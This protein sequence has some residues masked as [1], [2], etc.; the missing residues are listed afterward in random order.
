MCYK[1]TVTVIK[2]VGG[3]RSRKLDRKRCFEEVLAYDIIDAFKCQDVNLDSLTLTPET[4]SEPKNVARDA[5]TPHE[6]TK[7]CSL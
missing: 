4:P 5:I 3:H 6:Y 7:S 2:Y 1:L